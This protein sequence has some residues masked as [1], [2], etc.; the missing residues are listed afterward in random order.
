MPFRSTF[1]TIWSPWKHICRDIFPICMELK[2]IFWR[3][4]C[5]FV[6][7]LINSD[8]KVL[9][10]WEERFIVNVNNKICHDQE[11]A[12]IQFLL[13]EIPAPSNHL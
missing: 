7:V 6:G 5:D 1:Q 10:I 12:F 11:L 4:M 8:R 13:T 2:E 9:E 3:K